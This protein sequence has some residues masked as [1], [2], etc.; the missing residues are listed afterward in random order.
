MRAS[1]ATA[2]GPC[3]KC[4]EVKPGPVQVVKAGQLPPPFVC[5]DCLS[6]ETS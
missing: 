6:K 2:I 4:G 1:S 5:S 3:S